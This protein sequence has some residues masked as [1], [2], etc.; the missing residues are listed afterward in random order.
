MIRVNNVTGGEL[1]CFLITI[2]FILL[3]PCFLTGY[4][5]AIVIPMFD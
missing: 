2:L 4:Y 3:L 1:V 5:D